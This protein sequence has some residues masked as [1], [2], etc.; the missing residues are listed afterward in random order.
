MFSMLMAARC[1]S[2]SA[3]M[4]CAF[5]VF[6][7]TYLLLVCSV[8]GV[9]VKSIMAGSFWASKTVQE[10]WKGWN[11]PVQ[12]LLASGVYQPLRKLGTPRA[13]ARQ[14]VRSCCCCCCEVF[15]AS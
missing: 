12:R 7:L 2:M 15:K 10:I 4:V 5:N 6:D 3:A 1:F 14:L 8:H 9:Q 11:L 13:V